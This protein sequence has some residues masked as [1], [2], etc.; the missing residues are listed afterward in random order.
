MRKCRNLLTIPRHD[1]EMMRG[2]RVKWQR[3]LSLKIAL[4]DDGVLA[5]RPSFSWTTVCLLPSE[6]PLNHCKL[7]PPCDHIP[8]IVCNIIMVRDTIIDSI[9]RW[10]HHCRL[11]SVWL[12][13][14]KDKQ[15]DLFRLNVIIVVKGD[16]R[17]VGFWAVVRA[18]QLLLCTKMSW[19]S[20]TSESSS[21]VVIG[22][23]M[24]RLSM[25]WWLVKKP[26]FYNKRR[27]IKIG[28]LYNDKFRSMEF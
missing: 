3:L 14:I 8:L 12:R 15:E 26:T 7:T 21:L 24:Y 18:N 20:Y 9:V 28:Y 23:G 1:D 2:S 22:W 13:E 10:C 4:W 5:Q 11:W 17:L 16:N 27:L 25:K 6:S 19:P